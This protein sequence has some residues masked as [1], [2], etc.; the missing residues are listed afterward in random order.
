MRLHLCVF[1][2]KMYVYFI[3]L[4]TIM[5]FF[6]ILSTWK[7]P[8]STACKAIIAVIN[9]FSS[10][11]LFGDVFVYSLFFSKTVLPFLVDK[12]FFLSA[13]WHHP[14]PSRLAGFLL[15]YLL[16]VLWWFFACDM[17]FAFTTFKFSCLWL[18]TV[19]MNLHSRF[20]WC[21]WAIFRSG[22]VKNRSQ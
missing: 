9:S 3:L 10:C 17:L 5:L 21:H 15:K 18:C 13:F 20:S 12:F 6:S 2:W 11:L 8:L 14:T 4:Y 7:P 22:G 19:F 1:I 16:T